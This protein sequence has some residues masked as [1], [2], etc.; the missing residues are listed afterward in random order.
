MFL[1]AAFIPLPLV[2]RMKNDLLAFFQERWEKKYRTG[3]GVAA[4]LPLP[5]V[6]GNEERKMIFQERWEKK[7]RTGAGV[8]NCVVVE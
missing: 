7:Y 8:V 4:I 3:V 1:K 5:L 6:Q 2:P